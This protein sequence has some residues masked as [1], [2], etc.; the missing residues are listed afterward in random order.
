MTEPESNEIQNANAQPDAHRFGCMLAR[1]VAD[2][3]CVRTKLLD[4]RGLSPISDYLVV[5]TGTSD[6]QMRSVA[7]E[8]KQLGRA[9]GWDLYG[10]GGQ[11]TGRWIVAD[12]VTV[13]VHL[14]DEPSREYYDLDSLWSD[15]ERIDWAAVTEPGEFSKSA[16]KMP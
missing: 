1:V 10:S 14:F 8:V 3:R 16:P 9:H 5:A 4:V 7:E 2:N 11:E 13:I 12:F 6:R 15:A